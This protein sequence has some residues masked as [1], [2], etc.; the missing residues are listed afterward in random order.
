MS[1]FS[2]TVAYRPNESLVSQ[3]QI[4][5]G[6]G[7]IPVVVFNSEYMGLLDQIHGIHIIKNIKNEGLAKAI[8]LGVSYILS[9]GGDG[10]FL[11]DQDSIPNL[12]MITNLLNLK[13]KL[14]EEQIQFASL[15]PMI[16]NESDHSIWP[17][18][19]TSG[20]RLKFLRNLDK[21]IVEVDYLIT[22]G[23]YIPANVG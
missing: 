2:V 17:V 3:I 4:L 11:F 15:G 23:I 7:M 1:T 21:E 6:L 13:Q 12:E 20:G 16:L 22:S 14:S 8:N 19:V 10:F 9:K 18:P 5:V